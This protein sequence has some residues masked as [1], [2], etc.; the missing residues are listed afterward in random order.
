[1]LTTPEFF[2]ILT[3]VFVVVT[4]ILAWRPESSSQKSGQEDPK[5]G[6]IL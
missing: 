4:A 6:G 1:M 2:G 5:K 3:I